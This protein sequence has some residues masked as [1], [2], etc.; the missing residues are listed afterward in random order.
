MRHLRRSGGI[1]QLDR[2]IA[3]GEQ[4]RQ[5]G[6]EAAAQ[7]PAALPIGR[8][9]ASAPAPAPGAV[10]WPYASVMDAGAPAGQHSK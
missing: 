6:I 9:A 5:Q 3:L 4:L 8:L 7:A 1:G 10:G 2:I